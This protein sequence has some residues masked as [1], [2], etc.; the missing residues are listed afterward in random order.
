[1]DVKNHTEAYSKVA[2]KRK[3]NKIVKNKG[4]AGPAKSASEGSFP[5]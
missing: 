4:S 5:R 1:M 3:I 2:W